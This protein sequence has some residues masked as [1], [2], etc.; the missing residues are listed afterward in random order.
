M[1]PLHSVKRRSELH[2]LE[3]ATGA[4]EMRPCSQGR[5]IKVCGP[6]CRLFLPNKIGRY[7]SS[8]LCTPAPDART[9]ACWQEGRLG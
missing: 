2:G 5:V 4:G 7:R 8:P 6:G 3:S 9:P 1:R